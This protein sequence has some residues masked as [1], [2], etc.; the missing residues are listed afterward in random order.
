M[1][2]DVFVDAVGYLD[3]DV[4]ARHL[5]L[6]EKLRSKLKNKR[7]III[8]R[9]P[10]IAASFVAVALIGTLLI[11]N[12]STT[13]PIGKGFDLES[14]FRQSFYGEESQSNFCAYRSETDKFDIN[15]VALDFY[16]GGY[17]YNG[18]EFALENTMNCPTFD[19]Y[20]TNDQGDKYLVKHVNENFV[21]DKYSC[22]L[23]YDDNLNNYEVKYNYAET[24]TIPAELF[25]KESGMIWLEIEGKNILEPDTDDPKSLYITG[26]CIFYNMSNGEVVLSSP[27]QN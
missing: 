13:A 9:W 7:I 3:T 12:M 8:W 17:Y 6:K 25:V 26:I 14:G 4:L 1:N 21:S 2:K 23:V 22:K 19:I 27:E 18:V 5:Q 16:Y 11:L 10:A 15:H 24:L 20:F